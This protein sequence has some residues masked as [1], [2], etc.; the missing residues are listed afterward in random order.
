MLKNKCRYL[1]DTYAQLEKLRDAEKRIS[2]AA[3]RKQKEEQKAIARSR[4]LPVLG[5]S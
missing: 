3:A 5:P 2:K 1:P 4:N